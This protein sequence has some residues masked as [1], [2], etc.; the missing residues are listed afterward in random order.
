MVMFEHDYD[1]DE[2][3]SAQREANNCSTNFP[4]WGFIGRPLKKVRSPIIHFSRNFIHVFE[5]KIKKIF[6]SI[7]KILM[8]FKDIQIAPKQKMVSHI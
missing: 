7:I 5:K 6:K 1:Y 8:F 3:S 2:R 4:R